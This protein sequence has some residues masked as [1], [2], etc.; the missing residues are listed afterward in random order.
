MCGIHDEFMHVLIWKLAFT[1]AISELSGQQLLGLSYAAGIIRPSALFP[2]AV[3]LLVGWVCTVVSPN[4]DLN[5][6]SPVYLLSL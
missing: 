3:C 4:P 1:E 2:L 5:L 6:L